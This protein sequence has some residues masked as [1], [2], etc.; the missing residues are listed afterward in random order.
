MPGQDE[1]FDRKLAAIFRMEAIEHVQNVLAG[2]VRLEGA[3][4]TPEARRIADLLFREIHSLKGAARAVG[5]HAIES[6]CHAMESLLSAMQRGRLSWSR[7]LFDLFHEVARELELALTRSDAPDPAALR[8]F[9]P[10]LEKVLTDQPDYAASEVAA[11]AAPLRAAAMGPE[12]P[13]TEPELEP[14]PE[15]ERPAAL[16]PLAAGSGETVRISVERLGSLLYQVEELVSAKLLAQEHALEVD[17]AH[18]E[19]AALAARWRADPGAGLPSHEARMRVLKN[20]A[21]RDHRN[22]AGAVD[23]LLAD[24]K[25]ALMLPIA[26]VAPFMAATVRELARSQRKE[27]ELRIE[28]GDVEIDRRLLEE[29]REPLVHLLRNSVDHGMEDAAGRQ[30]AGKPARGSIV[31][32]IT[33]KGGGEVQIVLSDDGCG[34]DSAKLARAGRQMGLVVPE[35]DAGEDLLSLVFM[36]G[37]ST[38]DTLTAVSGRGLGLAIVQERIERL[39]GT[40]AVRSQPGAGTTFT[41][42]LPPSLAT[43]RAVEVRAAGQSFLLPTSHVLRCARVG[44]EAIG[45]AGPRQTVS[46][47]DET[48]ALVSLAHVLGLPAAAVEAARLNCL[49]LES[50]G[51]KMAFAVDEVI[52]EQEV[53]SKPVDPKLT[54]TPAVAGA[55]AIGSGSTVPI[56]NV[57]EL[58]RC[59]V[60]ESHAGRT[61]IQAP[62]HQQQHS[63]LVVE[64]SI[65]SRTLLK[66]ILELA[67]Y[68]VTIAVDGVD[69]LDRLRG[70]SFDVVVSDIEMPRLDGFE[71]TA[72][73]RAEPSLAHIPVVLV[74]SLSSPADRE[75]GAEAGANAYIVKSSFDQGHLLKAIDGLV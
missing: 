37:L 49:V 66:N 8:R 32:A 15:P 51:R 40:I 38:A 42:G 34:I 36:H 3:L 21:A 5:E 73:I 6:V 1:Q 10:R 9:L 20:A 19:F 62:R 71:L 27:V 54:T 53:L 24:V 12:Q 68:R 7:S 41:M 29:L 39:G 23:T 75:R 70:G 14:E 50:S 61:V 17:R 30:A 55:A 18:Q 43:F 57:A 28:G 67:G 47:D 64:D 35:E 11:V 58:I 63:I 13:G 44:A 56:L 59:A 25:K 45:A 46:I 16:P 48:I 74:T 60:K 33:Q 65:T 22:L 52:G 69:G 31:L 72:A 2:L 26:S 4:A